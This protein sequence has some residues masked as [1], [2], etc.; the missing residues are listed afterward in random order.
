MLPTNKPTAYWSASCNSPH[1]LSWACRR[2]AGPS[3]PRLTEARRRPPASGSAAMTNRT[4]A[5]AVNPGGEPAGSSNC[6]LAGLPPSALARLRPYLKTI[7]VR[8]KQVLQYAGQPIEYVYFPNGGV[9]SVTTV[10]PDGTMVEAATVGDEGMFPIEAFFHD[11][12]AASGHAMMQVADC[13]VTMP[14]NCS[15]PTRNRSAWSARRSCRSIRAGRG[16]SD[17]AVCRVQRPPQRSSALC[18]LAAD[19]ARSCAAGGLSIEP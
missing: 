18:A 17:D 8:P 10:L 12:A 11:D 7:P 14:P 5:T 15:L 4:N 9:F 13:D 1:A 19:D 3:E 6:L 16:R 2:V